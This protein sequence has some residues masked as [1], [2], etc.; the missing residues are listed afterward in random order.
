MSE[1]CSGGAFTVTQTSTNSCN[2]VA[3]KNLTKIVKYLA[4]L[5]KVYSS[6]ASNVAC[7]CLRQNHVTSVLCLLSA[8]QVA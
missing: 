6:V 1:A 3:I 5:A 4:F 8:V 2:L 7:S